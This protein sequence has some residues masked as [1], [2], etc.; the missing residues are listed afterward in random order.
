MCFIHD[1]GNYT[2]TY[3]KKLCHWSKFWRITGGKSFKRTNF[4][5][6]SSTDIP[7]VSLNFRLVYWFPLVKNSI[8][9]SMK[10]TSDCLSLYPLSVEILHH[11]Y[12]PNLKVENLKNTILHT[13]PIL[14]FFRIKMFDWF[15]PAKNL[16][17]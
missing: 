16:Y 14:C 17:V 12:S 5:D 11:Y 8:I 4:F 7:L 10:L 13:F 6:W 2:Q 1:K 9:W 15:F 3:S